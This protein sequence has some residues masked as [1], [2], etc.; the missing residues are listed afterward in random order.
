M[1]CHSGELAYVHE[2]FNSTNRPRPLEVRLRGHYTHVPSVPEAGRIESAMARTIAGRTRYLRQLTE[3]RDPRAAAR[4]VRAAGVQARQR[5]QGRRRLLKDP[6]AVLS[7]AWL[8]DTFGAQVVMMIRHPGAYVSSSRRLGWRYDF[9]YLSQQVQ[10]MDGPWAGTLADQVRAA[11]AQAPD[12]FDQAVLMWQLV[13]SVV[14]QQRS[15]RPEWSFVTYEDLA[16]EPL[17]GFE[18]LYGTLGLTWSGAARAA[19]A[20][21]TSAENVSD[22]P[23]TEAHNT[24]R[25]S[26]EAARTWLGRLTPEEV[27]RVRAGVGDLADRFY[28][29]STWPT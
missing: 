7:S 25:N 17:A 29:P 20:A 13:Y 11:R 3:V 12:P 16:A 27:G 6:I 18:S 1:L 8:A 14:D 26:A 4:V 5:L 22:R 28:D 2:P 15:T 9:D 23:V 19:I 24:R 10:L 21:D